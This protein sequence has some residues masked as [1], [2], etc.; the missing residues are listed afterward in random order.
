MQFYAFTLLSSHCWNISGNSLAPEEFRK[1]PCINWDAIFY[2]K[3][4]LAV[5][6]IQVL[7]AVISYLQ[8]LL[9]TYLTYK[10]K[11]IKIKIITSY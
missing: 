1:N 7:L 8:T 4:P 9:M 6:I 2:I 5:W 11:I 10:V 3:T